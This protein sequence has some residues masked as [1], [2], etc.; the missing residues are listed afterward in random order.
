[1][2]VEAS[3]R[4]AV[5]AA[6]CLIPMAR[7]LLLGTGCQDHDTHMHASTCSYAHAHALTHA[8]LP[9]HSRTPPPTHAGLVMGG[10]N[11]RSEAERLVKGVNLLVSTPGRLLD[12]LQV[13][14]GDGG[15]GP[16][17]VS[18]HMHDQRRR[19]AWHAWH[20]GC[21]SRLVDLRSLAR[22]SVPHPLTTHVSTTAKYPESVM[23]SFF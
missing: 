23:Q 16:T 15:K 10:A 12:H 3:Q 7:V 14:G 6:G 13:G 18:V 4:F 2:G 11:R 8:Q 19:M 17:A 21:S 1:M 9:T 5:A 22:L 20:S